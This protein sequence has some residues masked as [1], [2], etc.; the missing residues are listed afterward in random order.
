MKKEIAI[1][2]LLFGEYYVGV[3]E[4]QN[5]I[6]DKKYYCVNLEVAEMTAK[7]LKENKYKDFEII[8]YSNALEESTK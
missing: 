6:L 1:E 2:A 8:Y 7:F 5:L 4:N 3:Y